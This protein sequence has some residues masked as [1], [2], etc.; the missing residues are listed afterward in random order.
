MGSHHSGQEQQ[1]LRKRSIQEVTLAP[2]A[3]PQRAATVVVSGKVVPLW[4][5]SDVTGSPRE[6]PGSAEGP[7]PAVVWQPYLS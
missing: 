7:A 1:L 3:A 4:L 6:L 2:P 5:V